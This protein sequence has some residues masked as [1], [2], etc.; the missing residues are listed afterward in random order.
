MSEPLEVRVA[1]IQERVAELRDDVDRLTSDLGSSSNPSS[2]R[3][4][5]HVIEN[6]N[7]ASKAASAALDARKSAEAAVATRHDRRQMLWLGAFN[8]GVAAAGVLAAILIR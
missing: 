5:L 8:A 4:R 3:G 6:Y 1:V 2:V 7:A